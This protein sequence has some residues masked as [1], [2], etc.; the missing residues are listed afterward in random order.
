MASL[1]IFTGT[2][3][4]CQSESVQV[5][6]TSLPE[7]S[8]YVDVSSTLALCQSWVDLEVEF[9][10]RVEVGH[11]RVTE[12]AADQEERVLKVHDASAIAISSFGHQ[13]MFF[14]ANRMVE[15]HV[16]QLQW[17]ICQGDRWACSHDDCVLGFGQ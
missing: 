11:E 3:F 16:E 4:D 9:A 1:V 5:A 8:E 2:E 13:G 6:N 12:R 7:C 14:V 17:Q 15:D 10:V